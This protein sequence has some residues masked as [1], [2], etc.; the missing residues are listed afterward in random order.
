MRIDC[1]KLEK[2]RKKKCLTLSSVSDIIGIPVTI[3][4]KWES[5]KGDSPFE[6]GRETYLVRAI[7]NLYEIEIEDLY[8]DKDI[9]RLNKTFDYFSF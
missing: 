6:S 9:E 1:K 8:Y 7:L 2:A 5:G 4:R 3:I